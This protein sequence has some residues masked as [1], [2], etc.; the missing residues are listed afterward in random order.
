[1]PNNAAWD[2]ATT[3]PAER[4]AQAVSLSVAARAAAISTDYP[5]ATI[6]GSGFGA[7]YSSINVYENYNG[8]DDGLRAND[9]GYNGAE[10]PYNLFAHIQ[11]TDSH[12]GNGK[13]LELIYPA[14]G[15]RFPKINRPIDPVETLYAAFWF[16]WTA[17]PDAGDV[18]IFK[19][20]RTGDLPV[21]SASP[22]FFETIRA[23]NG[24]QNAMDVSVSVDDP[25]SSSNGWV[26]NRVNRKHA[27]QWHWVEFFCVLS[28]PGVADGRYFGR[29]NGQT[30]FSRDAFVTRYEADARL[31]YVIGS[32]TGR[33]R[34]AHETGVYQS[35]EYL[36]ESMARVVITD[37]ADY[38]LSTKWQIQPIVSWSSTS[39]TYGQV[40]GTV[41]A[42]AAF[43]HVFNESD[44]LILSE[45]V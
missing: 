1:M 19:L 14:D 18:G 37:N 38:A 10:N 17:P 35:E 45:A 30:V 40:L 5:E 28:T 27:N 33:D 7:R 20:F 16:K 3:V 29:A 25:N 36:S 8:Y 43:R 2:T 23:F 41:S 11:S 39:I 21:Y 31:R 32:F 12:E 26:G 9:I 4:D 24:I 13:A 44:Q 6:S 34:N 15:N 22:K 42:A